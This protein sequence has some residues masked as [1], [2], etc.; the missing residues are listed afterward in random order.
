MKRSIDKAL[1]QAAILYTKASTL[2]EPGDPRLT[3]DKGIAR[4]RLQMEALR[5]AA[6]F[7][8]RWTQNLLDEGDQY[9]A[10]APGVAQLRES[11]MDAER[12]IK[13]MEARNA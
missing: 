3:R 6:D 13:D 2:Y 12:V 11:V 9:I 1:E 4:V 7:M 10:C 5:F 8:E